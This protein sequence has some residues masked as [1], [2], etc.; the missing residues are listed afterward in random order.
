MDEQPDS[1]QQ[2][3]DILLVMDEKGTLQAVS[4][5]KDG[6]LQTKN[7]LEDNND[8]LRVDRH[9]DM[10]SNFFSNLW[11]QLKDPTRFH[12]FR[13]PEEEMQRV[14]A[15]FQQRTTQPVKEGEPLVAQYEVQPPVQG[16]Q[17]AQVAGQQQQQ[18][19]GAPQQEQ[20]P[21]YKYRP[22]DIDWNSLAAIG[23]QRE[24]IERNGM[25][26]QMLRGF[27]TDKTV[28]VHFRFEGLSHSNDSQL[29]LKPDSDGKLTVCS[30]GILDPEKV[31]KQFFGYDITDSDKQQL[32]QTG[33]MG[34]P[35][36]VTNRD[37]EQVEALVSRNLKTNE[38]IAFPVGKVNIPAEKNGHKFTPD[39]VAKLRQGEAVVCQ[40][41][42]K[43]KEGQ[44]P[45][46]Y[47][48]PVQ[49]S[50]AKMQLEFLFNERGKQAMDAY[51]AAQKQTANQEVP[52]TFRKQELT[53]KSRLELEA[54]GTVKVSGLVD[55][56][57]KQYHGYITWK[58]GEK[59]DFMFPKDY[60][61]ALEE[62]RVKPA[63]ENEVQ[64]AVNSQGKTNEA[65][66]NLKEALQSAQQ[67][68]T[69]EQKQRQDRKEQQKED[70]KQEQKQEQT[71]KPK[72]R[73]GI[74]R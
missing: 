50:A 12:F 41:I 6:E 58:P 5:V 44:E 13:V 16:Q 26:D 1:S 33:N 38:L 71:D 53:E 30:H 17:Q 3:M 22:E 43:P 57:G 28:R 14:A 2:L 49:F 42:T 25:L 65:T 19:D 60:K 70:K 47:L 54:G 67:R 62:G 51:R 46:S 23:V 10:F 36:T 74:R 21:Q 8:L 40:F 52:K 48:A 69:G 34:H 63:V 55:K 11:N 18:Q 45:K 72:Q 59:P 64:V 35:A 32:Q 68:P 31:Q 24:Q 73:K 7:P 20:N 61:A 39:E 9:G 4:G 29:S 27:Q 66:R 56:K 37:G 15:D